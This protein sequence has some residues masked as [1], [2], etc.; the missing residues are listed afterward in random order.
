METVLLLTGLICAGAP[1]V[2]ALAD[3][4][5]LAI[6]LAVALGLSAM[7][8]TGV[9][10]GFADTVIIATVWIGAM[11]CGLAAFLDR[12]MARNNRNLT[13]RLLKNDDSGLNTPQSHE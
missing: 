2:L 7:A 4:R 11:I 1:L 3:G 13:Y 9:G 6:F 5:G 12:T 10:K 8:L